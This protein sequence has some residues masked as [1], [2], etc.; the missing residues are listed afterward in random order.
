MICIF[1]DLFIYFALAKDISKHIFTKSHIEKITVKSETT[2]THTHTHTHINKEKRIKYQFQSPSETKTLI[3]KL[4]RILNKLHQQNLP[5]LFREAY[6][7]YLCIE[8]KFGLVWF[9]LVLWHISHFKLFN[10]KYIFMHI[11]SYISNNS[12]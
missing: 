6:L 8:R 1:S 9:G 10:V 11:N 7:I 4:E 5:L 2:H 3:R 12:V